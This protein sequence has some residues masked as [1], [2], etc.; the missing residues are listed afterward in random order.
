MLVPSH[1]RETAAL[2]R[3]SVWCVE[4]PLPIRYVTL[5]FD[6]LK[7]NR[8]VD[9][10]K[11]GVAYG[12]SGWSVFIVLSTNRT[13]QAFATSW[14]PFIFYN[15]PSLDVAK[16][17]MAI[18]ST[19]YK[20]LTTCERNLLLSAIPWYHA[21][22]LFSN[23]KMYCTRIYG[24]LLKAI[25]FSLC[26]SSVCSFIYFHLFPSCSIERRIT[27]VQVDW[28]KKSRKF[29]VVLDFAYGMRTFWRD[30]ICLLHC[31]DFH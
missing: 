22:N 18:N 28:L 1:L 15:R 3:I 21:R 29:Y 4:V 16:L 27:R 31:L 9:S 24:N 19:R 13:S 14:R 7:N 20:S 25:V 5:P 12:L 30:R 26:F 17:R 23:I 11:C 6:C 2:V 8:Q 10:L